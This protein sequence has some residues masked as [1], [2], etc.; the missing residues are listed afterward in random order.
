MEI[1][2][3][4]TMERLIDVQVKLLQ[5]DYEVNLHFTLVNISQAAAQPIKNKYFFHTKHFFPFQFKTLITFCRV[6]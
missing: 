2:E 5:K 3:S 1:Y 4:H 6:L